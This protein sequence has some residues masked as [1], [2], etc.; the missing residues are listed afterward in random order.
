MDIDIDVHAVLLDSVRHLRAASN[1]ASQGDHGALAVRLNQLAD[2][3]DPH[4][5]AS[6]ATGAES[7]RGALRAALAALDEIPQDD[8]PAAVNLI[9]ALVEEVLAGA[10]YG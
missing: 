6:P 7:I 8:P 10:G 2:R 9:R 5:Y 4:H 3:I 1:I